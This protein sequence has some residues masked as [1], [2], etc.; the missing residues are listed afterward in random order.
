[1][2]AFLLL[3]FG[4]VAVVIVGVVIAVLLIARSRGSAGPV[5][6]QSAL[7][8]VVGVR[9]ITVGDGVQ[10]WV[11]LRFTDGYEREFLATAS[12]AAVIVRGQTGTAHFA[13]DRLTGWVPEIGGLQDSHRSE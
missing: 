5:A 13:G 8:S 11:G 9:E 2:S 6:V 4:F 1:M 12:Q 10:H 3:I 7:V